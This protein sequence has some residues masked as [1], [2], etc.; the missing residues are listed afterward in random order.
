[1]AKLDELLND[2]KAAIAPFWKRRE[3]AGLRH[4]TTNRDD[5]LA[6]FEVFFGALKGGSSFDDAAKE[7]YGA[8]GGIN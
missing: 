7:L 3:E 4:T 8:L 6:A 5:V 1:V 2:V